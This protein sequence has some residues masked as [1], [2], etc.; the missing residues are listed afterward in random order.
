M[1]KRTSVKRRVAKSPRGAKPQAA[2]T[3]KARKPGQPSKSERAM[4][5]EAESLIQQ[6]NAAVYEQTAKGFVSQKRFRA[7]DFPAKLSAI[8]WFAKIGQPLKLDVTMPVEQVKSL[9]QAAKH[10][11]S[12]S[13]FNT[14]IDSQNQLTGYL[15]EHHLDRYREWNKIATKFQREVIVPLT[16]KHWEPFRKLHGLDEK[17][18]GPIQSSIRLAFLENAYLDCKHGSFFNSE[19][20]RVYEAG[21]IPCRWKGRWPQGTLLVY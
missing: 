19:L 16:K 12:L 1:A 20:F 9:A 14:L 6:A 3:K 2:V 13:W 11:A 10:L 7:V 15:H 18:L 21:H 8:A 17:C 4:L 5:Q